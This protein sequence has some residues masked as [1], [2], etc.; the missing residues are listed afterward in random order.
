MATKDNVITIL[1][2]I[3]LSTGHKGEKK[4]YKNISEH[5]AN[6]LR[7]IIGQYIKQCER[8]T[9]KLRKKADGPGIVVKPITVN[10]LNQSGQTDLADFRSLPEGNSNF[11]IHYQ[12][13]LTK[14]N[15]SSPLATIPNEN[16]DR[17][18]TTGECGIFQLFG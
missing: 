12:E 14:Y 13:H 4:T 1:R 16:Y 6:I 15:L 3:Y 2:D 11:V 5:F 10:E 9:E 18:K 8:C 17:S 7:H